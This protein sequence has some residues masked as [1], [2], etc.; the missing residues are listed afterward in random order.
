MALRNL[1]WWPLISSNI[2]AVSSEPLA[3][4]RKS[5]YYPEP[6]LITSV[7]RTSRTWFQLIWGLVQ[8]GFM[9]RSELCSTKST[10]QGYFWDGPKPFYEKLWVIEFWFHF[11]LG[12][13]RKLFKSGVHFAVRQILRFLGPIIFSKWPILMAF[14]ILDQKYLCKNSR[15]LRVAHSLGVPNSRRYDTKA[16]KYSPFLRTLWAY[17]AV[18]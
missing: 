2:P 8:V 18:Y 15:A 11:W 10:N 12:P 16:I 17:M 6:S 14:Y 13:I 7:I 5:T 9:I 3:R 4:L 1:A